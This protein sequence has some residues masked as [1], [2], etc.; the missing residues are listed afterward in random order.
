MDA[1]REREGSTNDDDLEEDDF[2]RLRTLDID[3]TENIYRGCC[4][5]TTDKRL[6][7]LG[8]QIG[9][10]GAILIFSATMIAIKEPEDT[11]L[12]MSLISS[13]LSYWFGRSNEL[14]HK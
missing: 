5:Y 11:G 4:N 12:Y 14:N 7:I 8:T 13:I 10:S 3:H 2:K 1:I 9:L 6:L